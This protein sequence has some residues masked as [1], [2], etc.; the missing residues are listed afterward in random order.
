MRVLYG[1]RF[2]DMGPFRAIRRSALEAIGMKD[3]AFG[4]TIEMQIRAVEIGLRIREVPVPY[5]RRSGRSKISWTVRG[6]ALAAYG[7]TQTCATLWL[8]KKRRLRRASHAGA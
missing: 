3:R 7:I 1:R 8:T 2:T 5:R 6:V 4:W